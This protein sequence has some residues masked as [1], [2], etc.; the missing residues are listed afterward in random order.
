MELDEMHELLLAQR[1]A[2]DDMPFGP[3]VAVY[4]VGG[5]MFALIA[6]ERMPSQVNLKCD[7]ERAIDLRQR[8]P[9]SVLPGYHMSKKHWNTVLLDGT[10]RRDLLIELVEHSWQLI[11]DGLTGAAHAEIE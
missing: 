3:D 9:E 4:R 6:L 2:T 11:F 5:K 7:P 1:G 10:V 8:Y